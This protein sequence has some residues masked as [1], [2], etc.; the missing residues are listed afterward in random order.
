MDSGSGLKEI[1]TTVI[2]ALISRPVRMTALVV[3]LTLLL[4]LSW[5]R[6]EEASSTRA[7]SVE[8]GIHVT[9][10]GQ[11]ATLAGEMDTSLPYE[12]IENVT[13]TKGVIFG[14][15]SLWVDGS[16]EKVDKFSASE[17][18]SLARYVERKIG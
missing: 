8:H 16:E 7:T 11:M 5:T 2:N 6:M 17:T 4:L 10:S 13:L 15:L 18:E 9:S 14:S 12:E 1:M 3:T